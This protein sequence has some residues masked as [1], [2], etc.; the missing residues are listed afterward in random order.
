LRRKLE[1]QWLNSGLTIDNERFKTQRDLVNT[2]IHD[3]KVKHY[4]DLITNVKDQKELFGLTNQFMHKSKCTK[5]PTHGSSQE[6]ADKFI[7]FFSTKI[8]DIRSKIDS[9]PLH[10]VPEYMSKCTDHIT[11]IPL[12]TEEDVLRLITGSKSKSCS[13]DPIPTSVLKQ[14]ASVM[15]PCIREIINNSVTSGVMPPVLKQAIITPLIKKPDLDQEMLKNYR[16]VS[17][18]PYISKLIEKHVD[19]HLTRHDEVND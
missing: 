18:L 1:R 4:S 7:N 6:L 13:L 8:T 16:P 5:L 15:M 3:S 17:N 11:E 2:M 19:I 12:A 10:D 14:C 9:Q